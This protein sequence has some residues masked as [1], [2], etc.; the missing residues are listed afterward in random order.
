MIIRWI[1]KTLEIEKEVSKSIK[2]SNDPNQCVCLVLRVAM[3][4]NL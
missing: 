4:M 3:T 2:S 1:M